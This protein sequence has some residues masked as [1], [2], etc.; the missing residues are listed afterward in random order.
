MKDE[1]GPH[2]EPLITCSL[3]I[4]LDAGGLVVVERAAQ[5]AR[6]AFDQ[7]IDV[8]ERSVR[9]TLQRM[10]NRKPRTKFTQL[11]EG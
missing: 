5:E 4:V 9:K 10:R 7:A 11:E 8:A 3:N 6:A 2:G 1:S